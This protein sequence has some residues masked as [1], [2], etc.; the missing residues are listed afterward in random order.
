MNEAFEFESEATSPESGNGATEDA[1][2]EP[3][4]LIVDDDRGLVDMFASALA[5]DFDVLT[6]YDGDT[7]LEAVDESVD[8]VVL[9]RRMPEMTG[10]QV[11][12]KIRAR[13]YDCGVVM[14]TAVDPDINVLDMDFDEYAVKPITI[15]DLRETVSRIVALKSG[16]DA[17]PQRYYALVSK[18]FALESR[19]PRAELLDWNSYQALI[20]EI[21]ERRESLGV[22]TA[23]RIEAEASKA[24]FSARDDRSEPL[25]GR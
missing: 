2:D 3:V 7:A 16:L 4:V 1:G 22:D 13:D 10:D 20:E 14:L 23:N 15:Q 21:E 12:E 8:V 6:A 5:E 11:L 24:V 18:R 19:H 25:G 17:G 9:D